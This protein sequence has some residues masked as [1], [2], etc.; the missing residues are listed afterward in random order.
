MKRT[1]AI[2]L[3]LV[4]FFQFVGLEAHAAE[5]GIS[6]S[7]AQGLPGEQVSVNV[8]IT[9]NTGLAYLKIK[10][11]YDSSAL[12]LISAENTGLLGGIYTTSQYTDVNPYVLQWM[13]AGNSVGD[14]VIATITFKI[15]DGAVPGDQKIS[16]RFE[17]CYDQEFND[18]VFTPTGS[19]VTIT[20]PVCN[21]VWDDGKVTTP[22][23]CE[24]PGVKTYTCTVAGCGETKTETIP[25]SGHSFGDWQVTEAATCTEKGVETR[26]C[27]CGKTETREIAATGHKYGEWKVTKA[28]TCT[29]KG[30]ETRE[31]ACGEKETR[32]ITAAGHKFGEWKETKAATCT[33]KGEETRECA[34]GEKETREIAVKDHALNSYGKDS[35]HHWALC[36]NCDYVGEKEAHD[37][38]YN[39]VCVCGAKKPVADDPNLDDVP[40]T[41]DITPYIA[42]TSVAFLIAVAAAAAFILKRK[43]AK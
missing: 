1:L 17:E 27:A 28:A 35:A 16:L 11:A 19:V 7:S 23:G 2:I 4:L 38:D 26:E 39:G 37:Y 32:E 30:V 40:K 41:G 3:A 36:D 12:T 22:A 10:V 20:K 14:G 29:E 25:A 5:A 9:G 6:L 8:K 43:A 33:K 34:C 21:H 18:V 42:M 31:C 13:A 24:T 15:N